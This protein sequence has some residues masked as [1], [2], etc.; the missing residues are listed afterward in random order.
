MFGVN[1]LVD[2]SSSQSPLRSITGDMISLLKPKIPLV[3]EADASLS[4]AI[5]LMKQHRFGA[6]LVVK[7]QNLVGIFTERDV[8][9]KVVGEGLNLETTPLSDIMTAH[10]ESLMADDLI[11]SALNRM[12]VGGYRH[13]PLVDADKKLTGIISIKDIIEYLVGLLEQEL[14]F[15]A[16]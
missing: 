14:F 8:L 16:I 13:I 10:P 5:A 12:T 15:T 2:S 7:D 1:D 4:E 9:F 3:L 6:I 11:V